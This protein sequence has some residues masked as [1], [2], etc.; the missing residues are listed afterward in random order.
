[1]EGGLGGNQPM[2][3]NA[4]MTLFGGVD[5]NTV[6]SPSRITL[7]GEK[8]SLKI[9]GSLLFLIVSTTTSVW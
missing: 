7:A 6:T 3:N 8:L 9:F 1:M 4:E 5:N 2:T